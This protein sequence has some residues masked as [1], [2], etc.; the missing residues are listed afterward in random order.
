MELIG[1]FGITSLY[2]RNAFLL[3]YVTIKIN[4]CVYI[5]RIYVL[6]K[7]SLCTQFSERKNEKRAVGGS[8]VNN[9]YILLE[10]PTNCMKIAYS[11]NDFALC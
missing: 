3:N 6:C 4:I 9:E 8:R 5:R 7:H 1:F 11:V 10:S 2:G